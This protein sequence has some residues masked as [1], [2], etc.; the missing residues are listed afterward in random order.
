MSTLHPPLLKTLQQLG[1]QMK[2]HNSSDWR[3]LPA[4]LRCTLILTG[5]HTFSYSTDNLLW[6]AL[7]VSLSLALDTSRHM[8]NAVSLPQLYYF[9][10]SSPFADWLTKNLNKFY[11]FKGSKLFLAI[12]SKIKT[13]FGGWVLFIKCRYDLWWLG[14]YTTSFDSDW[15]K[16]SCKSI[17]RQILF[18]KPRSF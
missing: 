16:Q 3:L 12:E 8:K 4:H 17:R 2:Q 6:K 9:C 15:R 18:S 14:C 11:P 10:L 5:S 13:L 1:S 7:Y